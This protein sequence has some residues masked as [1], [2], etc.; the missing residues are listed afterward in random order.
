M[1]IKYHK[2]YY[3]FYFFHDYRIAYNKD[4][5]TEDQQFILSRILVRRLLKEPREKLPED[6]DYVTRRPAS[7]S[8]S[9]ATIVP[10]EKRKSSII[11][12]TITTP[13]PVG[14]QRIDGLYR[15]EGTTALNDRRPS[16]EIKPCHFVSL[17]AMLMATMHPI[18]T[19]NQVMVDTCIEKGLEIYEKATNLSVCE[20][21]VI[22]N[23]ILDG[24]F[25]NINIKKIMVV[26]ENPEKRLDQ[27]LRAVLR[28]LRYVIIRFPQCSMVICQ[29][30]GYYHLFD[31]YPPP[32]EEAQTDE[33]GK[34]SKKGSRVATWTLYR[35]M[36]ALI[37]RIRKV[38]P[39]INSENPEFYTF[40]LTS[41]KTAPRH[42]A[43]N[44]RLSPLFKPDE[45]P[46]TPYL[47][48]R[49][50]RPTVDEKMYWLNIPIVPWSRLSFTNDLGFE[51]GIPKTMWKNWD[52]EFPGDLYSL[53][54]SIHPMDEMFDPA[55]RG[56][57]YLATSVLAIGMTQACELS[58]WT[59][60]F[61]DGIVVGGDKYH[62][63]YMN[64]FGGERNHEV[65]IEKLDEKFEDMYPYSFSFKFEKVI[66]GF[67]YNILDDRFNLSKAL[68]YFFEKHKLGILTSTVKN[69]A[70]GRIGPSY[71]M[72]DCQ[73][74][75]APIFSPGTG[76]SYILKCES[77]NR[78]IYCMT[79][80]L[81]I[82]SHGQQFDL[83]SVT[84]TVQEKTK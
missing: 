40:E 48:R 70:F 12:Q 43:L 53:W 79:V 37:K 32:S 82:K 30:A 46:N 18:R 28:R 81:N 71:F 11:E 9:K 59:S 24:K 1:H 57:Q 56:K 31:A 83:Y 22:K 49:K 36:D 75:G 67:V 26:N 7:L 41:V 4:G 2:C 20:K 62:Q 19:W 50:V 51:R 5:R 80:T 63:L 27:Y 13:A 8:K 16:S 52:I 33:E 6:Y 29:T 17:M 45:N 61:L 66:F 60:G 14:Y 54:G 68:T 38:V 72:F 73:S 42:S 76:A 74:H 35:S 78:L 64:K 84:A 39:C 15:I 34:P 21:R 23:V 3:N 65:E 77:L 25:I 44:Y 55:N 58:A 69:L 10:E 47:K